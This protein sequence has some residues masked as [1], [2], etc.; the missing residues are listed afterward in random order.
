[1][2]LSKIA[3]QHPNLFFKLIYLKA[4]LLILKIKVRILSFKVFML[5]LDEPKALTEDRRRAMLV[6]KFFERIKNA[7]G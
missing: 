4:Q 5:R 2:K 7:H 3:F 6:D 1:M